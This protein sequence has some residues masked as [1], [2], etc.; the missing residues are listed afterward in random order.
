MSDAQTS[1]KD[2][3]EKGLAGS[4]TQVAAFARADR[5]L[6]DRI[7]H[8]LHARPEF[9]PLIV[10]LL[11]LVVFGILLGSKFF[12]PFTLTLILQQVAIVGIVGCAQSLVILTAGIDLSVGAI[13]VLSSVVM[14][15]FTF[16]Y[17]LPAE[18]AVLCGLACGALCGFINGA[19]VAWMR[20]PPFIVTLGMWQIVLA[21]N[22]LY[23]ANETIRSQDIEANAPILQFFGEKFTIGG[24]VF[25]YGVIAMLVLVLVLNYV[26]NH[27]A[28]GR[29][30][31]AIGDDPDAAELAGVRVSRIRIS[32]YTLAG[33]I[34]A[35]AGWAMIGR[36][37]SVSPTSGQFTNIESITAV[38]IGGISLFG[39]R[40]SILGMLFGALIVGVFSLGLRLIGTDPQWTYLLIG[41]LIIAAVAIDQWIRKVAA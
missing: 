21:T 11:S 35:I 6:I 7:Q 15:Q 8:R 31:Y 20:L 32:V 25:T 36:L 10:L 26:L 38:V 40:G 2:D 3:F 33:L 39:G 27:T 29:H 22:F 18:I 9:V 4:S 28:W 13:M 14:G 41:V 30:V 12:S 17:G 5:P 19:L 16:R 24:A 34:C 23:S 1:A 37:G